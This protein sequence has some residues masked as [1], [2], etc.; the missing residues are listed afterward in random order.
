MRLPQTKPAT[1]E[2]VMN[3]TVEVVDC[4]HNTERATEGSKG[5]QRAEP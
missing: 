5:A 4:S 1:D 2:S 3:M